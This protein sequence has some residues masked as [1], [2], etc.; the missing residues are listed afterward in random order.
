M[1]GPAMGLALVWLGSWGSL[2]ASADE[3]VQIRVLEDTGSRI[4]LSYRFEGFKENPL[5]IDGQSFV[6]L[7]L[8]REAL[9]KRTGEPALPHVCRSVLIPDDADMA[10]RVVESRCYD[11]PDVAVAPSKGFLPRSVNPDDVPYT[12]GDVYAS[13]AF[14]PGA[15]VSLRSPH[16]LRDHRGVVAEVFPFQWNPVSRILRVY[17][18]I[19]I[20]V[21]QTGPGTENILERVPGRSPCRAFE[22]IYPYHFVNYRQSDRYAPLDEAG[23]MLIIVHDPWVANI[24]P[25][26]D[27]KTS[28]GIDTTVV[29]VSTIGNNAT[30]IRNYIQNVYNAGDLAFVLLV[31]DSAQVATPSASGGAADP[32]Y[33]KVAGSDDY[34]DIFVGRF[35]AETAAHVDTQVQRT[36]Q[37]EMLP[38]TAQDWYWRA[39]GIASSEG[40][41]GQGDDNESDIQHMNNIRAELLGYNYTLVN[42]IYD[43]GASA[44]SVTTAL[45]AGRG[46]VNYT[47]HGSTTSWGTTGFSNTNVNALNNAGMLPFICSVACVNGDFA[48]K[49]C[50]AEAWLRATRGGQPSGAVAVYMSSINQLWAPPMEA[51]DEFNHVLATEQY[52]TFGGLCFAGSCSMI[53]KYGSGGVSTF[54]TWHIFGD[55]SLRVVGTVTPPTGL[56]VSPDQGLESQGDEGGPFTPQSITYTLGNRNATPIS[57]AVTATADW[58]DVSNATGTLPGLGTA[59]VTVSIN[60]AAAGLTT[61]DYSDTVSF[62]NTTD[63]DGNTTRTV[64]L[65]VGVPR[66]IYTFNMDTNPGWTTSGLWAWGRPMGAGGS[67]GYPDP[68]GGH[69]GTNVYGYNLNGDYTNSMPERHLTS[70]AIDCTGLSMVSLRF[71]RWLGVERSTYDHAYVRVSNNGTNW[72]TIWQNPDVELSDSSWTQQVFDISAIA[73]DQPTLYVRWTMGSTDSGWTYC[74]WN[75]DDVEIWGRPSGQMPPV[76][77]DGSVTTDMNTPTEVTLNAH[78]SSGEPLDFIITRL[79]EHGRLRDPGAGFLTTV[80]VTLVGGGNEVIFVPTL[81]YAG[82]DG[83]QFRVNDGQDSNEAT[84]SLTVGGPRV[85]FHFPMDENPGWTTQGQ[86]AF[87]RPIGGGGAHGNPDPASGATGLNVYGYN[88]SGDYS[89]VIGGPYALTAGPF[90]LSRATDV[91]LQYQR[92]LNADYAPYVYETVDVS[93]NGFQWTTIWS[94]GTSAVTD[95]SWT[96]Q[97][98]DISAIADGQAAVYVRWTHRV[99]QAGAWAYS[100]WN[101]DDVTITGVRPVAGGDLDGDGDVDLADFAG[102]QECCGASPL[103][104]GC[105]E[106]DMDGDGE[107][108]PADLPAFVT[109]MELTGPTW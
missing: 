24:Q 46:L 68:T 77:Y 59:T 21:Y 65:G 22:Q 7:G 15:L 40:G 83:F 94:N 1:W 90:D 107:V 85:L 57:Y 75:I 18:E 55:P 53:D 92:W 8:G 71:W 76:A 19:T 105:Q 14:Y 89:T 31:G 79:P 73:D 106:G 48:G 34:P 27:H 39:V 52:V 81:G 12:F 51:Q 103:T 32:T 84:V 98:H 101:I 72:T 26:A 9:L 42:Q 95:S 47:G 11:V 13:D 78:A 74:G 109:N 88:L 16:I 36:I 4:V 60:A 69:T 82:P 70:T 87:G 33:A 100:G 38:A 91:T 5:T 108:G 45:N 44:S 56:S 63:G 2:A 29:P 41:A 58:V 66:A 20:E 10:V 3:S 104:A 23:G 35:S 93:N 97:S 25:L 86:W 37:H 102:F 80:P 67:H 54:N 64:K 49:T 30:S 43:P 6:E 17:T 28:I 62:V 50:F 96:E 99:A 61:G